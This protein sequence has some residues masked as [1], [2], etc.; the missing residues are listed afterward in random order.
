MDSTTLTVLIAIAFLILAVIASW[1]SAR[2]NQ[3]DE[4]ELIDFPGSGLLIKPRRKKERFSR[5]WWSNWIQ[6]LSTELVGAAIATL[7]I[8]VVVGAVQKNE[9]EEALRQQQIQADENFKRELILQMGSPVNDF[10]IEAA[11]QLRSLGWL[12]DGSLQGANLDYADLQDASLLNANLRYAD[13]RGA[14]LQNASLQ[15]A[16]LQVAFLENTNLQ[17]AVLRSANL[18]DAF[19]YDANLRYADL[20]DANLQNAFLHSTNLQD[21][22]LENVNLQNAS[23]ENANLQDASLYDANLQGAN[24]SG[25]QFNE[26]TILPDDTKWTPETDMTRFTNPNHPQFWRSDSPFSSAYGGAS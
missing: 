1:I 18:Q 6:G 23:L 26:S 5:E 11:R 12:E 20:R 4:P 9:A 21:T 19:L 10:A 17:N 15:F 13:L 7:L 16:K 25:T 2:I 3:H 8:G 24:L 14:N 22:S